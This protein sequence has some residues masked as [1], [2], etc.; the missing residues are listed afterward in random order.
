MSRIAYAVSVSA[1]IGWICALVLVVGA[2]LIALH[3]GWTNFVVPGGD[4]GSDWR[5]PSILFALVAA[6]MLAAPYL[7][8][9]RGADRTALL[10]HSGEPADLRT[11]PRADPYLLGGSFVIA[12][13]YLV[14]AIGIA[15]FAWSGPLQASIADPAFYAVLAAPVCFVIAVLSL[16]IV[17]AVL[18]LAGR[19]PNTGH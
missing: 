6:P 11:D 4:A 2:V 8:V 10:S 13:Y 15:W 9:V 19:R 3:I 12:L 1:R 17:G 18:Q 16:H 5:L 7:L 14:V